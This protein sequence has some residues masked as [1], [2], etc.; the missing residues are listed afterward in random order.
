MT[1]SPSGANRS[2]VA[3]SSCDC[4]A[5]LSTGTATGTGAWTRSFSAGIRRPTAR[6]VH[7]AIPATYRV[8]STG[9]IPSSGT[10]VTGEVFE[11]N[12]NEMSQLGSRPWKMRGQPLG[13]G[14]PEMAG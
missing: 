10:V 3:P 7:H 14:S 13:I 8:S 2:A 4:R 9:P 5:G 12:W 6:I 1:N 11:L